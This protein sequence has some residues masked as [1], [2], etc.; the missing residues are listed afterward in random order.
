MKRVPEARL[1]EVA[2]AILTAEGCPPAET[3]IVA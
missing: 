1:L 3:Q 2:H